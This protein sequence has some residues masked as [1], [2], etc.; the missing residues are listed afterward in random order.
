M[1][2]SLHHPILESTG[3]PA[4]SRLHLNFVNS[5]GEKC[6][7]MVLISVSLIIRENEHV[8]LVFVHQLYVISLF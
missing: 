8:F 7:R 1:P 3:W 6:Y 5:I 2:E 4:A